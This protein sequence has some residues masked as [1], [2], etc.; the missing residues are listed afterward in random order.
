MLR[1]RRVAPMTTVRAEP[2]PPISVN[3]RHVGVAGF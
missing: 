3:N 1:D 2:Q